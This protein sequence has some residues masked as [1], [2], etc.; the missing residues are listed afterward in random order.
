MLRSKAFFI[1][2][3]LA[4][5]GSTSAQVLTALDADAWREDL[6][7]L[8]EGLTEKHKDAF[9][10][11]SEEEFGERVDAVSERLDELDAL[12]IQAELV[13]LAAS[14][15]D[16]HTRVVAPELTDQDALPLGW[17]WFADGLRLLAAPE[18]HADALAGELTHVGGVGLEEVAERLGRYVV[19]DNASLR[20]VEA[21]LDQGRQRHR[22]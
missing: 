13:A 22:A 5:A 17:H 16:S 8:A 20:R 7:A 18:Q 14:L 21:D 1:G 12:G 3:V 2:L 11:L 6:Y 19:F 4:T 9:A 15:G 10:V